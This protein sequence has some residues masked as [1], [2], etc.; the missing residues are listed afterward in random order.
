MANYQINMIRGDTLSFNLEFT[1]LNQDLDT[2]CF[3]VKEYEDGDIIFQKYLGSGITKQDDNHYTVRIAPADTQSIVAKSYHFDLEITVNGDVFTIM[4]GILE[5]EKD[6][7]YT[8][9]R[10]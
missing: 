1:G 4:R 9:E 5:I 7:T 2:A 8:A 3:T 10:R 6:V